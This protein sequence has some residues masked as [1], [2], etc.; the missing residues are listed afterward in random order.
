MRAPF[1]DFC[2]EIGRE[3]VFWLEFW[4]R[5]VAQNTGKATHL[6]QPFPSSSSFFSF[7]SSPLLLPQPQGVKNCLFVE[8]FSLPLRGARQARGRS[9]KRE[10]SLLSRVVQL[11]HR[12]RVPPPYHSNLDRAAHIFLRRSAEFPE[13]ADEFP[14]ARRSIENLMLHCSAQCQQDFRHECL[15]SALPT[16]PTGR[17]PTTRQTLSSIQE[18]SKNPWSSP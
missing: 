11:H 7:F 2:D 16:M 9:L 1:C 5:R 10:I 15:R 3:N 14:D 8:G 13:P 12:T 18:T 4:R 6:S 17:D